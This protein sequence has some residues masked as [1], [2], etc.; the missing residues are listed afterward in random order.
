MAFSKDKDKDKA[1][2]LS[3]ALNFKKVEQAG[4]DEVKKLGTFK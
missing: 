3:K 1:L 2:A 4:P